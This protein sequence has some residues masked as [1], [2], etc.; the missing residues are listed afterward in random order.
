M[1]VPISESMLS[2]SEELLESTGALSHGVLQA[3]HRLIRHQIRIF[4]HPTVWTQGSSLHL[5]PKIFGVRS[6]LTQQ[7]FECG[8]ACF[9]CPR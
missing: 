7:D 2:R 3:Q 6:P 5:A 4:R 9:L 8:P 1:S